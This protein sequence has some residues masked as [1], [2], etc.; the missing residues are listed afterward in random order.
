MPPKDDPPSPFSAN[1][2]W[3]G[4][5]RPVFRIGPLPK[6]DGPPKP[7]PSRPSLAYVAP[8]PPVRPPRPGIL[9]GSLIP[10]AAASAPSPAA[11]VR[12]E[13]RPSR[14][15]EPPPSPPRPTQLAVE[16]EPVFKP[17]PAA[18]APRRAPPARL[19]LV[20]GA[21]ALAVIAVVAVVA[22]AA[23]QGTV[24]AD[25]AARPAS[26]PT[27]QTPPPGPASQEPVDAV[28]P[29]PA[30][31]AALVAAPAAPARVAVRPR[32]PEIVTQPLVVPPPEVVAPP[33]VVTEPAA[34]VILPPPPDPEAA[35]TTRGPNDR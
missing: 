2:A 30:R 6:S 18:S 7:P 15:V 14:A 23:R 29:A 13:A 8:Q 25:R 5:P 34:P 1:S 32:P 27:V 19:P 26:T 17:I 16:E 21:G 24:A 28:Q 12:A 31:Q 9:T 33:P 10:T 35:M 22:V 4:Q 20:A 3:G 11:E